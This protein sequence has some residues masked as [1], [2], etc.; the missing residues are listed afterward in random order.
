MLKIRLSAILFL[1]FLLLK[2][3][4]SAQFNLDKYISHPWVDSVFRSLT[5]DERIAQ[6]IWIDVK[7]GQDVNKQEHVATLLQKYKF[8][9]LVFFAGTAKA[10][11][12]LV[13]R[14]QALSKVPLMISMDAE[15]G[16]AMRLDDIGAFPYNLTMGAAADD[17]LI[18]NC[19]KAM[20][21]QLK[22]L[23]VQVSLGPVAD[24]NTEPQNPIIGIR[25]FGESRELVTSRS[26]AY[27]RGLQEN[28]VMAVAKHY[29]G[30]GDTKNDSHLT[31]PLLPVS[32]QRLDT[33]ELVPF[34]TL[35][36]EG[37]GGIMTAHL[38]VPALDLKSESASSLSESS[39]EGVI[40]KE[41][42]YQGLIITD[43]MNMGGVTKFGAPGANEVMALKAG[44]DIVE[45]PLDGEVTL[46]AIKKA[47][48]K[49][50]IS[51]AAINLKC[52]RALAAKFL[53]GLNHY[54][55]LPTENLLANLNSSS[56]ELSQRQL[57]ESALTLLENKN[58]LIPL[59]A[60]DTLHVA[61]L[62]IG[63]TETTSFQ[64]MLSNYSLVDH[65][66]LPANFTES[67]ASQ[68]ILKLKPYN[69]II[70]GIHSLYECR[71]RPTFKRG[72]TV[73]VKSTA[74][75]GADDNLALLLPKISKLSRSI[76]V[77]FANPY[78][79]NELKNLGDPEGLL[80][81]YQNSR[82]SQELAAQLI[83]GGIGAS[84][85]LPVSLGSRY[86]VGSGL[87]INSAIRMKYTLPEEVGLN[88]SLLGTSIDSIVSIGLT[89]KA[90]PGCNVLIAKDGN[91]I[92]QKAYGYHTYESKRASELDDI[93]DLASVTKAAGALPALIKLNDEG[94]FSID[95]RF[96]TY[97]PDW[98]N[99]LLHKS[100]KNDLTI[101]ELL[102]HQS[103]LIPFISFWKES[104]EN[105]NFSKKWYQNTKDSN[106]DLEVIPG[107]YLNNKFKD[108]VYAQILK[109]PLKNRGKY[110]YSDLSFLLWPEVIT[111]L[112][113][114]KY[115]DYLDEYFY[116]PLG[117]STTTYLP[118]KK[119]SD[120][121]LV[122]T[123]EDAVFRKVLLKNSV[124]DEAAA[125]LGGVSGNAGLYSS[126][127]DLAKI[128]QLFLQEGSYGGKVYFKRST[129][130]QFNQTQFPQNR[131]GLGFDKPSLE[132][133]Q[134]DKKNK[135]PCFSASPQS[136]G[137]SGFTGTFFWAD[138][139][140]GLLYIFLSN[141]V[142]PSRENNKLSELNIRTEILQVVYDQLN[143]V[144]ITK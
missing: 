113:G 67:E 83:F 137:H 81:G 95:D 91:I 75:Y 140:N 24:I 62:S 107:L 15:W 79:I 69:L 127:N 93:Y 32:R 55:P 112:S 10:Q 143:Q 53:V 101:R 111:K 132:D 2:L 124:D 41:W 84:G 135:Y 74:P 125:V 36:A 57:M 60:L 34:K 109:S 23:G 65:F 89:A 103:G 50:V 29:P 22:N 96:S 19:A 7:D 25:S 31:L 105:N 21:S 71:D 37:I 136:F 33:M 8:G 43:A 141:R 97:W 123:E 117:A 131:R 39:V 38:R 52:R 44:N 104:M 13:N 45:F 18:Q 54:K 26:L 119:F 35:A 6:L 121:R 134:V 80:V 49:R 27:M 14:Y 126:A 61:S 51:K 128:V 120:D 144:Q 48:R 87:K 64:R 4:A 3:N 46:K 88:T 142:H 116:K 115:T 30:H 47:V 70:T 92:F 76:V 78:A 73:A 122:P 82:I 106:F 28:G 66:S 130:R 118:F 139:F 40:R 1:M 68:L 110:L 12:D 100:N 114:I 20:A 17:Q 58:K 59:L 16:P 98:K 94:K 9:G 72:K 5:P 77:F 138:P 11:V 63:A 108:F 99:S 90:Y 102:A 85:K 86:A 133:I 129:F 42:N 56:I